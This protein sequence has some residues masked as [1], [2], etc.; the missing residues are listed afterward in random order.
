MKKGDAMRKNNSK[1][2]GFLFL[3]AAFFVLVG[4]RRSVEKACRLMA[5]PV[6]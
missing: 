3:M 1:K 5:F 2:N 4:G 6:F